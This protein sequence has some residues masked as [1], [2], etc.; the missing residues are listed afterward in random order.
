MA[1]PPAGYNVL[2]T[3]GAEQ[4]LESIYDYISEYDTVANDLHGMPVTERPAC[5][6]KRTI[7]SG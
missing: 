2:L 3:E 5:R 6:K 7:I 1:K 4:E